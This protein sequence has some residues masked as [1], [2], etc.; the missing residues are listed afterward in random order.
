MHIIWIIE[1]SHDIE[2][3]LVEIETAMPGQVWAS[4][5]PCGMA[6]H[7]AKVEVLPVAGAPDADFAFI[8]P[9]SLDPD[10]DHPTH[11]VY[12]GKITDLSSEGL[13]QHEPAEGEWRRFDSV[14]DLWQSEYSQAG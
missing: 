4:L 6:I 2:P 13:H 9:V 10:L 14:R 12:R 3:D 8:N 1:G 11:E 7:L 5:S